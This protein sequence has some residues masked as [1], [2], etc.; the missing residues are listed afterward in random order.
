MAGAPR[1]LLRKLAWRVRHAA[2]APLDGY[3]RSAFRGLGREFDQ[4]VRYEFG[5]DVRDIDW[6]VTARLGEPYRKKFVEER[7]LTVVLLFEDSPSLQFGSGE[8]TKRDTLLE[9]SGLFAVLAAANRDRMGFWYAAPGRQDIR[10]PARGRTT[11]LEQ[12]TQLLDEAEPVA[13]DSGPVEIDWLRLSRTF[14]RH[15]VCVWLGDFPAGEPPPHW[16]ALRRRYE[17]IGVRVEDPWERSLPVAGVL[18]VVD[19]VAG[20][21]L[22]LDTRSHAT[23]QRHAEW[24]RARDR[25]FSEL[26]PSPLSRLTITAGDDVLHRLAGFFHARGRGKAA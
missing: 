18:P 19:P 3:Y 7:E 16:K 9:L 21:V 22:S 10:R 15:T 17:M 25:V 5:D 8:V 11:I 2:G 1:P 13:D 24:V 26:F 20:E 4:V 14:S 23:R 6:N 12:A